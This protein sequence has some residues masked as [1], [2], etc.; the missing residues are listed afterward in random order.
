MRLIGWETSGI[1]RKSTP[2][3]RCPLQSPEGSFPQL[4]VGL[5]RSYCIRTVWTDTAPCID[6]T[7][8]RSLNG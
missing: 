8:R 7:T 2:R 4:R 6:C 5:A 1:E 3:T